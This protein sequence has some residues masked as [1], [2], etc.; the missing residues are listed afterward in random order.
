MLTSLWRGHRT[1]GGGG[2]ESALAAM[3]ETTHTLE[4]STCKTPRTPHTQLAHRPHPEGAGGAWVE[5][6]LR[7]GST[8]SLR[9]VRTGECRTV[10]RFG[11]GVLGGKGC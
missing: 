2:V 8:S 1:R 10:V 4:R 6:F 11:L 3:T 5:R 7:V 9:G